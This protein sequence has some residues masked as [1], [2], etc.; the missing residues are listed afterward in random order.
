MF[1]SYEELIEQFGDKEYRE[2]YADDFLDAY[3]AAQI[4]TIRE[5]RGMTQQELAETIG[6][7][8][9]GISRIENVNYSGRNIQTLKK[10]AYAL[11]GRLHVS[12]E[13]FGS[14]LDEGANFSR[15]AL[16][17]PSVE[18]DPVLKGKLKLPESK[19][20]SSNRNVIPH[21]ELRVL[22]GGRRTSL[23]TVPPPKDAAA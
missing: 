5:Q 23:P 18:N 19:L 11:G 3:I 16:Q 1:S 2:A 17:R 14:L 7:K 12:I 10:I 15:R 9:T 22:T 21:V 6:T 4:R 20:P 8:Q 13:T